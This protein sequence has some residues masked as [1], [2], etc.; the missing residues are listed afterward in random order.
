MPANRFKIDDTMLN[1]VAQTRAGLLESRHLPGWF[2]TS[3][4]LFQH[5]IDTASRSS[6]IRAIT[7][8]SASPAS[9]C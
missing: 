3:P 4:E 2:Y 9:R 7:R 6:P 8:R 5:E 1:E